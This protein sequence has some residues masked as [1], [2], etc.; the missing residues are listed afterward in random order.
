MELEVL[1]K[2]RV[3]NRVFYVEAINAYVLWLW[4]GRITKLTPNEFRILLSLS[5]D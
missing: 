4:D 1:P 5:N 3:F 2:S